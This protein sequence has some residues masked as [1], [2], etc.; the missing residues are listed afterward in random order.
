MCKGSK[1]PEETTI[2][3]LIIYHLFLNLNFHLK[4]KTIFSSALLT[5]I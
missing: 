1:N 2:L 3:K 5:K 4:L